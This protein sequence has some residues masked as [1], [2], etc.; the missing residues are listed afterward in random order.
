MDYNIK[1]SLS[2]NQTARLNEIVK[3]HNKTYG[4]NLT[5][6]EALQ[7]MV[8]ESKCLHPSVIDHFLYH[9]RFNFSRNTGGKRHFF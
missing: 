3:Q 2:F 9:A 7:C 6:A 4:D 5:P 1:V 8:D